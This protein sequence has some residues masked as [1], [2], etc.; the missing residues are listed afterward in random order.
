MNKFKI[1]LTITCLL[2]VFVVGQGFCAYEDTIPPE[3]L[4]QMDKEILSG[5]RPT[6]AF[7]TETDIFSL[8]ENPKFD[9]DFVRF[10]FEPGYL[11]SIQTQILLNW[12]EGG[13]NRIYFYGSEINKYA[14]YLPSSSNSTY[15]DSGN[16]KSLSIPLQNHVVNTDCKIVYFKS[17]L[18]PNASISKNLSKNRANALKNLSPGSSAIAQTKGGEVV[19]GCVRHESGGGETYFR[20]GTNGVDSDRWRLN[21]WHWALGLPVP[22]AADDT[23]Y[24]S[25]SIS[26]LAEAVRYDQIILKNNDTITGIILDEEF[27]IRTSYTFLTFKNDTIDKIEFEGSTTNLDI[28]ILRLGDKIS[29][30]LE[31]SSVHIMLN[32]GQEI[33]ID[34]DKIKLIRFKKTI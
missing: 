20:V 31:N 15:I 11:S 18:N 16:S 23:I 24:G 26:T 14:H 34:N 32:S 25:S 33:T 2:V 30:N 27:S 13:F 4:A 3:I 22:G 8:R 9:A 19:A 1:F 29:G 28:I 17:E 5:K 10:N 7:I 6:F 12:I 21:Y